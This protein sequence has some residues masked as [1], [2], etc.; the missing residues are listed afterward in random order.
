MV[1][2]SR[3]RENQK[4]LLRKKKADQKH[5]HSVKK[6]PFQVYGSKLNTKRSCK[7]IFLN[8]FSVSDYNYFFSDY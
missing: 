2:V 6:A 3:N 1:N 4:I 5:A 8:F 7:S